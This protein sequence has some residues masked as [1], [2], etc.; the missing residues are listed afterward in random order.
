M[1]ST[2]RAT[3]TKAPHKPDFIKFKT[4][5][6]LSKDTIKDLALPQLWHRPQ[7]WHGFDPWS[8]NFHMLRVQPKIKKERHYQRGEMTRRKFLQVMYLLRL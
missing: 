3:T 6:H 4:F 8:R 5:V 1:T 7:L 2:V